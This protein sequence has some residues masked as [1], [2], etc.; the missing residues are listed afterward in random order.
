MKFSKNELQIGRDG[1]I[2]TSASPAPKAGG[3]SRFPT[4]RKTKRPRSSF[5]PGAWNLIRDGVQVYGSSRATLFARGSVPSGVVVPDGI[6]FVNWT[7]RSI[8]IL[9]YHFRVVY[10]QIIIFG[11]GRF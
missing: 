11:R 8:E 3:L 10:C 9:C 1:W 5:E 2:R 7:I 4:S 6:A